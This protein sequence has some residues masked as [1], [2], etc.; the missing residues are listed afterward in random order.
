MKKN[1]KDKKDIYDITIN[2][3]AL[4]KLK[5]LQNEFRDFNY[6]QLIIFLTNFYEKFK[7]EKKPIK[8]WF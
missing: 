3:I 7:S 1:E 6:S 4:N 5:E 2:Y 8:E